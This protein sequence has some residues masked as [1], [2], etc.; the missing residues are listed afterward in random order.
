MAVFSIGRFVAIT[1]IQVAATLAILMSLFGLF[2]LLG[3]F[4]AY[5]IRVESRFR[6]GFLRFEAIDD[7]TLDSLADKLLYVFQLL[8]FFRT[9][10]RHCLTTGTG[11]AG[12]ADAV[13]IVFG[14]IADRS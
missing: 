12:T 13:H 6:Q 1:F 8:E 3:L 5:L 2:R 9:Y 4:R 10:Q 7:F 11:A 14:H